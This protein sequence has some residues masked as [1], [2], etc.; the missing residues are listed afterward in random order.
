M[1][2]I[3]FIKFSLCFL[4]AVSSYAQ[5]SRTFKESFDVKKDVD[6]LLDIDN[7][8]II[9]E[10]WNKDRVEVEAIFTIEIEDEELAEEIL[11]KAI[12]EA[13]GNSQ[14]VEIKSKRSNSHVFN[15][16]HVFRNANVEIITDDIKGIASPQVQPLARLPQLLKEIE[17]DF[18][19]EQF[20]EEGKVYILEFQKELKEMLNDSSLVNDMKQWK[21]ELKKEIEESGIQDS[22]RVISYK[23][24]DKLK[25]AIREM[26][27]MIRGIQ[28]QHEVKKKI[29]IKMPKDANLDLNVKRSQLKIASLNQIDANLNYSGLQIDELIGNKCS[30]LASYSDI[31]IT[32]AKALNLDLRYAKKVNIGEIQELVSVSKTSNLVVENILQKAIIEGTFGELDIQNISTD[33]ELIEINLKNSSAKLKLPD[34]VYNFYINTKSSEFDLNTNLD[35]R[36]NDAFNA[37]IYQNKNTVTSSKVLNIK[38]DYSTLQL[39]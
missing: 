14:K 31:Q 13:L 26:K 36:V 5:T 10:T 4:I 6:V 20:N 33:F 19:M 38:A 12:F 35:Y 2:T 18:D 29:I 28:P 9:I 3:K 32:K 23:I 17:V 11:E 30:I 24:K 16:F 37:K 7:A 15:D 1:K 25:P 39:N 34:V 22:I 21:I 8:E 27:T